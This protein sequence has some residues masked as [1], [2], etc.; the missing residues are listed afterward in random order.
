MKNFFVQ[1]NVK[2]CLCLHKRLAEQL[3]KSLVRTQTTAGKSQL[4][5]F[6]YLFAENFAN[7]FF[8]ESGLVHNKICS[9]FFLTFDSLY[10]SQA[11]QKKYCLHLAGLLSS[12]FGGLLIETKSPPMNDF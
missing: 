10:F 7:L 8:P 4:I 9:L 1:K 3:K 12:I 11:M 2:W 6:E 5:L